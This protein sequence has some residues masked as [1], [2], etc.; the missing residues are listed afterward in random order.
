[1]ATEGAPPI[2]HAGTARSSEAVSDM[3]STGSG[4]G[5]DSPVEAPVDTESVPPTPAALW[6]RLPICQDQ[7]GDHSCDVPDCCPV[8][9]TTPLG[10]A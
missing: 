2:A 10:S 3:R 7:R 9:P 5:G 8:A 4:S 6:L 1:V